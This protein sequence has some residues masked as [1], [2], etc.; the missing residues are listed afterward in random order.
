MKIAIPE[1]RF[2]R[3][4]SLVYDNGIFSWERSIPKDSLVIGEPNHPQSINSIFEIFQKS[5]PELIEKNVLKSFEVLG[6]N[7]NKI[8]IDAVQD[9][10]QMLATI[11][12][13]FKVSEGVISEIEDL[14]YLDTFILCNKTLD[15]VGRAQFDSN[16]LKNNLRSANFKNSSVI[17][18][19]KTDKAGFLRK[20]QYSL[21][22]TTTGR[23]T[24]SSGPQILTAPKYF[25]DYFRSAYENGVIAQID[26]VSL[27]PRVGIHFSNKSSQSDVYE[28]LMGKLFQEKVPRSLMKKIVLCCAYG[29]S[30]RTLRKSLPPGYNTNSI[31][32]KTKSILNFE[33]IVKEQNQNLEKFGYIKNFFGRPIYPQDHRDT[34]LYNNFIQ[35]T[36]VDVALLGFSKIL[37]KSEK[38][39]INPLFFIHDA[40]IIDIHPAE[41]EKFK[42]ISKFVEINNLG[43]FPLEFTVLGDN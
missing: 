19:F 4:K 6:V 16:K 25:R 31:I 32:S 12:D 26:F 35:S 2:V 34:L 40:M 39:K 11:Q 41:V 3:N 23:M 10:K 37:D 1:S 15:R 7:K 42:E 17:R 38:M 13:I 20:P 29:A 24:I 28:Y 8:P 33:E 22:K 9:S 18:T 5:E 36:A 27:E 43:K 14:G 30:P 21:T